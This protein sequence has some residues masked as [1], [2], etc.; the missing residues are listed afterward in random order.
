MGASSDIGAPLLM[1]DFVVFVVYLMTRGKR[2]NTHD[3][4]ERSTTKTK[5]KKSKLCFW[6]SFIGFLLM[7]VM[8]EM[9]ENSNSGI[10]EETLTMIACGS[11]IASMFVFLPLGFIF[12]FI[13]KRKEY[14]ALPLEERER[15]DAIKERQTAEAQARA[16]EMREEMLADRTIVSTAIVNT[17][18]KGKQRASVTSSIVRASVGGLVSP[19]WALV[20][21]LTP[22]KT[23]VTKD[24]TVT[25]SILYASGKRSVETVKVGS[26]RY[27][28][29][30]KYIA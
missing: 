3:G 23:T 6:L 13:E 2:K 19:G 27:N 4:R 30:A 29:L 24:M 7:F 17:T 25:F 14:Q 20:G 11:A 15:L 26:K 1:V 8:M 9:Y 22:K 28:E 12:R 21:A 5:T 10:S 16:Q 18:S